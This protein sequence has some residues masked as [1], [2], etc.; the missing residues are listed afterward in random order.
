M[1]LLKIFESNISEIGILYPALFGHTE[2]SEFYVELA[3][4]K[5]L[6]TKCETKKSNKHNVICPW[7]KQNCTLFQ[8]HAS[9]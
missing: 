1:D 8:I 3:K 9:L 7:S 4:L 5:S 6:A 2:L